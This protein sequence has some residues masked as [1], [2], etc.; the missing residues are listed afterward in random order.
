MSLVVM[1]FGGS[2]VGDA[3]RMKRVAARI[4]EKKEAGHDCVVIVSA[5]GDTTDE[6]S[7][8]SQ[9]I[10]EAPPALE[11]DMLLT[12]GEQISMSLLAMALHQIGQQAVSF[13]GWQSGMLTDASHGKAQIRDIK[14]ER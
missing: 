11:M 13:T 1:K 10:N 3:E 4:K 12:T 7:D 6:L 2:S 9:Q 14:P 8:R 5:M